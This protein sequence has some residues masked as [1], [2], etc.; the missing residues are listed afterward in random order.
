MESTWAKA[1]APTAPRPP[2]RSDE[3]AIFREL[4]RVVREVNESTD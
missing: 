2:M 3:A 4:S 1:I